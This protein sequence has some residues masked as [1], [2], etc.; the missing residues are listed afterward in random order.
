MPGAAVNRLRPHR[1]HSK[2]P[3][4]APETVADPFA[5]NRFTLFF[6]DPSVEKDFVRRS[7]ASILLYFQLYLIFGVVLYTLFGALDYLIVPNNYLAVWAFRYFYV[8]PALLLILA[9]TFSP[10]FPRYSQ[11]LLAA[12]MFVAG[13]GIIGMTLVLPMPF[14][15]DYY[16]GLILVLIYCSSMLSMRLP[17]YLA[18]SFGVVALYY[19]ACTKLA[20]I[21]REGIINNL[22]FLV[23]ATAI[24]GFSNYV[25]E[26]YL[27]RSYVA[28]YRIE[29]QKEELIVLLTEAEA[30]NRAKSEFLAVMSHEL[31]TPLNAIIGFSE[32]LKKEILGPIGLPKYTE[33]AG[34]IHD[35]GVHL[36]SI[37]NDIL[38]LAK[39]ESGKLQIL[40]EEIGIGDLIESCVRMCAPKALELGVKLTVD[41]PE[42]T[43]IMVDERLMRQ[44]A[45][46]L[47]SNA[48]KFTPSGGQV[49]VHARRDGK[50]M[51]LR[52]EDTGIGI[53]QRDIERVLRPFE[54]AQS[55]HTR[56]HGGT[57]LGLPYSKKLVELHGGTFVLTSTPNVG[58]VI[59]IT[60]P[61]ER[62]VITE[63]TA[64]TQVRN[65]S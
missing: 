60:L 8:C 54:Q 53:S 30:A 3:A 2:R 12:V 21:P 24:G 44:V 16:A 25:M 59:D 46:N 43:T 37:I 13:T 32:I 14:R 57:G 62:V 65:A 10:H 33:Y 47:L 22:F 7:A 23:S 9:S 4:T 58:T 38:D 61:P 18:M 11:F 27:R 45:L 35:S 29:R 56:S 39:A 63:H 50:A 42:N 28:E 6:K 52:F 34:D 1:D 49:V 19:L 17:T 26:T 48:V 31:R 64:S 5:V 36:L 20:P 51:R 40:D 41:I 55:A 15:S